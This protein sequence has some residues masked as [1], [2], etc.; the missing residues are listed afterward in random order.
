[1]R[2]YLSTCHNMSC[3][4]LYLILADL[5]QLHHIMDVSISV[6]ISTDP[7]EISKVNWDA[8][9]FLQA[10]HEM[11][12][13]RFGSL[14]GQRLITPLYFS[15]HNLIMNISCLIPLVLRTQ[16]CWLSLPSNLAW[17]HQ[18]RREERSISAYWTMTTIKAISYNSIKCH[19]NENHKLSIKTFMDLNSQ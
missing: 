18:D 16:T 6:F 5:Y 7:D 15:Q 14:Y 9:C 1:M 10:I 13:S 19:C 12:V 2:W 3:D 17:L 8:V 11:P 4:G